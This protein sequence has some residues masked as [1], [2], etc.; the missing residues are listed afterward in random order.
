MRLEETPEQQALRTE[1]REYFER[2][3][4]PEVREALGPHPGEHCGPAYRAFVR[5]LGEDG[6]LGIGWP[7]EY[8]VNGQNIFTTGVHDADYLWLAARTAPDAPKHEGISVFIVETSAPGFKITP[9]ET[10]DDGRTNACY[11]QDMR[12]PAAM[13]V[14]EEN[15]G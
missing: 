3:L 12:V 2:A 5:Q 8:G 7:T 4:T 11:F 6:W 14:G 13:L 9:I 1:L 15:A 10:L